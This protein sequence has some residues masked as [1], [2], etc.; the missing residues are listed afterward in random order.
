MEQLQSVLLEVGLLS[1][2]IRLVSDRSS[3]SLA[4]L[5]LALANIIVELTPKIIIYW[6]IFCKIAAFIQ[7][8]SRHF[9]IKSV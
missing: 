4:L 2:H 5:A 1:E 6:N 3:R 8:F 9:Q 7:H